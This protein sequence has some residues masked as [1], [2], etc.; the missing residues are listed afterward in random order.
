VRRFGNQAGLAQL[1][2]ADVIAVNKIWIIEDA[3]DDLPQD[4]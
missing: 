3:T 1:Q 2:C 4:D